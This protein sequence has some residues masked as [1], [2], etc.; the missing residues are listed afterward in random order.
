MH[1]TSLQYYDVGRYDDGAVSVGADGL[2]KVQPVA[3]LLGVG[4]RDTSDENTT[5]LVGVDDWYSE[6]RPWSVAGDGRSRREA[7]YDLVVWMGH[8]RAQWDA[9][10][11]LDCDDTNEGSGDVDVNWALQEVEFE[12]G[13]YDG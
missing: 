9:T 2:P 1:T 8:C 10:V 3:M 4:F 6:L 12:D 7:I 11:W 13:G 5:M